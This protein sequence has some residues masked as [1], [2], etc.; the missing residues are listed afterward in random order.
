MS[1]DA[2]VA[3]KTEP[4]LPEGALMR[5]SAAGAGKQ[6]AAE[7]WPLPSVRG[8]A[9]SP[10]GR[11]LVTRG[12]PANPSR[13]RAIHIWD[14][15]TGRI[16]RTFKAHDTRLADVE[17]SPDGKY[18][19]AG[20]P[21]HGAG[22]QVWDFKTGKKLYSID[23]GR[24]RFHFL[25]DGRR[26]ALVAAFGSTDVVRVHDVATGKEVQRFVLEQNYKFAFSDDA[27][28]L[29]TIRTSG[30][31]DV[32]V[33]DLQ[34]GKTLRKLSGA[35]RQPTE[36]TF[37]PDGRTIAAATS[38]RVSRDVYEHRL[39][40]WEMATGELVHSLVQKSARILTM[41]FSPDGRFLATG[42]VAG[43]VR[44]WELA[45]GRQTHAFA[46]HR[47]PVSSL[48]FA[49]DG[50]RLASGSFDKSAIIW[51]MAPARRSFLP[52]EKLSGKALDRVWNALA[53]ASPADA[54]RAMGQL[55]RGD[56]RAI[57]ALKTRVTSVLIPAQNKRI[58]Q[59]L[60]ELDDDD[61]VTRNRAV[62][63]LRKLRKIAM[64]IL[65][66]TIKS[67]TSAEVRFRLR[68]ILAD[69]S[70]SPRFSV[71]DVRRM[72]RV[73]HVAE[74][75]GGP[76]AKSMLEMIVKDFPAEGVIREA[77]ATIE[78][79]NRKA[80]GDFRAPVRFLVAAFFFFVA[81][82]F[83]ADFFFAGVFFLA[84]GFFLTADF[85]LTF[86]FEVAFFF[87]AGFLAEAFFFAVAFRLFAAAFFR[88]A[89]GK[90][91]ARWKWWTSI[92]TG[93]LFAAF[94]WAFVVW[95]CQ[96]IT[97]VRPDAVWKY[98][99]IP[100][101]LILLAM[102]VAATG[103]D[104]REYLIPDE[105]VVAGLLAALIGATASGDLQMVHLWVDANLAVPGY[106]A[107]HI[108]KWIGE[109]PHW[110]GLAVAGAGML[111][112]AAITWLVRFVSSL[113]LGQETM[114]FGDVTLM[115]MIGAF[116]G[117]QP[118]LMVFVLAPICGII[119][120]VVVRITTGRAFIPYGP[121]LSAAALAVLFGWKW[122]W[123][124]RIESGGDEILSVRKMYGDLVGLAILGGIAIT[125]LIVLLG[126][127]R[128]YR[129]V[130][131]TRPRRSEPESDREPA[132][133][134]IASEA[135]AEES[136]TTDGT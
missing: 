94:V 11:W 13:A 78:R 30:R 54:Y 48:A 82:F 32:N 99:R 132:D 72:L 44:V 31:T 23:G 61:L 110:H 18:L 107:A 90:A 62:R 123:T 29:L 60:V 121:Y 8:L 89:A 115:G 87:A 84:T 92:G 124:F 15:Q 7:D 101:H 130:P 45:T 10:D 118:I 104:F 133:D 81:D 2:P 77:K 74:S 20:Q 86:F 127:L 9:F 22:L 95:E 56:E 6:L 42:S 43:K 50:K 88:A 122:L 125:A 34:T 126:L 128:L 75:V 114:G 80:A 33:V 100:F 36:F 25:P 131:V 58:Q 120:A 14:T 37:T 49:R 17:F 12:E 85:F 129:S 73:I 53:S 111:T 64:P 71:A 69:S 47:G 102:L 70:D 103:T 57:S 83:V 35:R 105:I 51:N 136:A 135:S 96:S 113:I 106:Q 3:K 39:L 68:R 21:E 76:V 46:G 26:F 93:F 40:V 97:E 4:A 98:G 24:G 16:A 108:P 38:H 27:R 65:L 59:L 134:P 19:V 1:A 55:S 119:V 52:D 79:L 116:L 41:R 117:W 112:G 28:R 5:L 91:S 66:K 63:E 67:T 109:H